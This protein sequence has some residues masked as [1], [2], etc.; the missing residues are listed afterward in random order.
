MNIDKK[1]KAK[2][3]NLIHKAI[4]NNTLV[5]QPCSI[6]GNK[7]S[8]AHH[9]DYSKPLDVIWLCR[10]HH[11]ERHPKESKKIIFKCKQCGVLFAVPPSHAKR[12]NVGFCSTS[13]GT[14]YRNTHN[15][16]TKDLMV[17]EKISLHHFDVSKFK[18]DDKG[19]FIG[20]EA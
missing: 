11:L 19:K 5:K 18:R 3:H 14:K 17:R 16:P 6:C 13:C 1:I 20:R 9:E 12:G 4:K 7:D 15:N 8:E 2:A 10:K